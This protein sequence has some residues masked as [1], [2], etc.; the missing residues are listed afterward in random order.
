M[1]LKWQK[2][3]LSFLQ[4]LTLNSAAAR[5]AAIAAS[6]RNSDDGSWR[7]DLICSVVTEYRMRYNLDLILSRTDGALARVM[8]ATVRRGFTPIGI[9]GE[10]Q[11]HGDR[12]Y[13]RLCVEGGDPDNL[14]TELN[15]LDDCLAVEVST[16]PVTTFLPAVEAA[17]E[18]LA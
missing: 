9:E 3:H 10:A 7:V 6:G 15:S 17:V 2:A 18:P 13:L 8:G 11:S 5:A 12:L 1:I 4:I 14:Q 16:C